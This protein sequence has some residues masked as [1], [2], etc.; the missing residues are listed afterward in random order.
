MSVPDPVPCELLPWDTEFFGCC[1]ARV[2]GDT[3][4]PEQAGQIDEWSRSHQVRA[5]YFLARADDPVTLQT[6]A[7]H[8]FELA[9]IRVT[10]ECELVNSPV[11]ARPDPPTGVAIRPVQPADLAALQALARTGHTETRFFSDPH[12]PRQRVEDLY[13]TWI[14]LEIQGG[15]KPYWLPLR[16][17]INLW[18]MSPATWSRPAGRGKSAWSGSARRRADRALAKAWSGRR[19]TGTG[20]G[21]AGGDGGDSGTESRGPT[22]LSAVWLSEPGLAALV[23]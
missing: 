22:A 16:P 8:G 14:A 21:C 6:A 18:V 10:F 7:R 19:L 12:F 11:P 15:P 17:F 4:K 13:S 2:C 9:D 20:L 5:L 1:I 23:S 3:L